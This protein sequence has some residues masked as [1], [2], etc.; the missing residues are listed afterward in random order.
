[1]VRRTSRTGENHQYGNYV[2]VQHAQDMYSLYAHLDAI[3]VVEG[4]LVWSGYPLGLVGSTFGTPEDPGARMDVPHLHLEIVSSWPLS[5]RDA[6]HRYDVLRELAAAGVVLGGPDGRQ[7]VAGEPIDYR[8]PALAS[9]GSGKGPRASDEVVVAPP[10]LVDPRPS[11][12]ALGPVIVTVLSLGA[13][14]I[15]LATAFLVGRKK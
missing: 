12:S 1:M 5:S 4:Q 2:L 14:A 6:Q 7:L 10:E 9:E 13:V 8:E 11:P 3:W 15:F